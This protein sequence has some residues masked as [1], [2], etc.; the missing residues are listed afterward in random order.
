MQVA[1]PFYI[2]KV[3]TSN[4]D[5]AGTNAKVYIDLHSAD[6]STGK[7]L[8]PR[9]A[10]TGEV[11]WPVK[12]LTSGSTGGVPPPSDADI[13]EV[14]QPN[15][16]A[17]GQVYEITVSAPDVGDIK[18]LRITHDGSGLGPDWHLLKAS[19]IAHVLGRCLL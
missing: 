12:A 10:R 1:P 17:T 9:D 11:V 16:F 7:M 18:Q 2:I 4:A 8:L 3:Q 14:G 6:R 19:S 13:D 5:N 15:P